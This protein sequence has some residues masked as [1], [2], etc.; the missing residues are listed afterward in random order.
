MMPM[1]HL[2]FTTGSHTVVATQCSPP[3]TVQLRNPANGPVVV[4]SAVPVALMSSPSGLLF[5]SNAA[6]TLT[7]PNAVIGAG[8]SSTTFYFRS[9]T[10]NAYTLNVTASGITGASQQHTVSPQ[11]ASKLVITSAANLLVGA[12][13]C[14]AL[15]VQQQEANGSPVVA[16]PPVP[17]ALSASPTTVS[18]LTFFTNSSCTNAVATVNIPTGASSVTFHASA[19]T[20]STYNVT[21]SS[22]A[23]T[24]ATQPFSVRPVVRS[25]SCELDVSTLNRVCL[26]PNPAQTDL[27]KTALF[28]QVTSNTANLSQA[29]VRCDLTAT[30][31]IF[32]RRNLAGVPVTVYWQTLELDTGLSV[33][34]QT[35]NCPDDGGTTVS[36]P[37]G[38]AGGTF[39]LTSQ[40]TDST[41]LDPTT[42]YTVERADGGVDVEW[43]QPC[44]AGIPGYQVSLQLV[45][46]NGAVSQGVVGAMPT[47]ASSASVAATTP[48]GVGTALPFVLTTQTL[49]TGGTAE[50]CSRALRT[51]STATGFAFTRAHDSTAMGCLA[52]S[53]PRISSERVYPGT[54]GRVEVFGTTLAQGDASGVIAL[55]RAYDA[56]RTVAFASGQLP[57][58]GQ[59][60]GESALSSGNVLGD[61]VA[62]HVLDAGS[63][64]STRQVFLLRGSTQGSARWTSYV[65]EVGP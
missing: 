54:A 25:G 41:A 18:P 47:G 39:V 46:L 21:V 2:A 3:V 17:L 10:P 31:S 57:G 49:T 32:C 30:S 29:A 44:V 24:P 8:S 16:G 50:L 55:P 33:L 48:A 6:C 62:A 58:G 26:I 22:G 27:A 64:F 42:L 43:Q 61:A 36:V 53:M 7:L 37:F 13:A 45:T 34:R 56:T 15:T 65:L 51:E 38:G 14:R 1:N 59:G 40:S 63:D 60:S 5:F 19:W 20:G 4:G 9:S 28:F 23:L 11:Q 12:G 35:V 52:E